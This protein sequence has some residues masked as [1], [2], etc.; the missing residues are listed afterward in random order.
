MTAG[1][2][3]ADPP[4]PALG[5]TFV[6]PAG[7]PPDVTVCGEN[8]PPGRFSDPSTPWGRSAWSAVT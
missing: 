2:A 1:S 7:H 3:A 4:N 8:P 5:L 6:D